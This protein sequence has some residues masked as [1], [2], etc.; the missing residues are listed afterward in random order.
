MDRI[1]WG[2][3]TS[4]WFVE[5]ADEHKLLSRCRR[6][7]LDLWPYI[8]ELPSNIAAVR[9]SVP[10][11][12]TAASL[13]LNRLC[14]SELQYQKLFLQ[15]FDLVGVGAD[16]IAAKN[17]N[18][19]TEKL[20]IT[21]SRI[22]TQSSY[23]DGIHAIVAAELVATLSCRT[24]LPWYERYFEKHADEYAPDL[25]D[26]GLGWLRLHTKTHTRHAIWMKRMLNDLEGE[27]SN[28][29][30]PAAEAV[31]TAMLALWECS[32]LECSSESKLPQQLTGSHIRRRTG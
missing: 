11:S 4:P 17:T 9:A 28:S 1:N 32:P 12:M 13:L 20:R 14:D 2:C 24:S 8:R 10:E 16:E 26:A 23:V 29:V 25:I 21:M 15:Q 6:T 22:C 27:A 18:P 7:I 19:Y 31:L 5:L 30:P 3:S